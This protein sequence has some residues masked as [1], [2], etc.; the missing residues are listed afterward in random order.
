MHLGQRAQRIRKVQQRE[1]REDGVERSIGQIEGFGIHA[2]KLEARSEAG[3]GGLLRGE[4]QHA[5]G[6]ID[7]EHRAAAAD[8][9]GG[10]QSDD[11]RSR[12]DVQHPRAG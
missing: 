1:Q 8:A 9:A 5:R 4:A 6:K 12:A 11:A 3:A 7:A 10:E 2:A